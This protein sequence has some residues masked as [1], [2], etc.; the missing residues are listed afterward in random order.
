MELTKQSKAMLELDLN[1][2]NQ[3]LQD[4]EGLESLVKTQEAMV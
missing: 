2:K 3:K 1:A 4:L